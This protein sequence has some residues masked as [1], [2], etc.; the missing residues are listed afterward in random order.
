MRHTLEVAGEPPW[1]FAV[2]DCDKL[3][4]CHQLSLSKDER[5]GQRQEDAY[6]PMARVSVA[7]VIWSCSPPEA[8]KRECNALTQEKHGG[9]QVK[10]VASLMV[11][12]GACLSFFFLLKRSDL[13]AAALQ[14]V[15]LTVSL[16]L[17]LSLSK[18]NRKTEG[19]QPWVFFLNKKKIIDSLCYPAN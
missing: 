13:F 2:Q 6:E 8:R 15:A 7:W 1:R 17:T 3:E 16:H 5:A 18:K 12:W 11:A 14:L 4:L 9:H 10:Q 19:F